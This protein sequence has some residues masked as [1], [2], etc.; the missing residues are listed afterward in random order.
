MT[1]DDLKRMMSLVDEKYIDEITQAA[2]QFA[3]DPEAAEVE[4]ITVQEAPRRQSWRIW[5]ALAAAVILCVPV[6]IGMTGG[7]RMLPEELNVGT[8]TGTDWAA[9]V[10]SMSDEEIAGY[11]ICDPEA[12]PT[13]E[14]GELTASIVTDSVPFA[15]EY[16]GKSLKLFRDDAGTVN[17]ASVTLNISCSLIM[18]VMLQ[19][20]ET[21]VEIVAEPVFLP[22]FEDVAF[23]GAYVPPTCGNTTEEELLSERYY[24]CYFR[25]GTTDYSMTSISMSQREL[26]THIYEVM[27]SAATPDSLYQAEL[28]AD[29]EQMQRAE[30][31]EKRR[32]EA[33]R[34][35]RLQKLAQIEQTLAKVNAMDFCKGWVPQSA[36]IGSLTCAK[37]YGS[38]GVPAES[39]KLSYA[40]ST[41]HLY[42]SFHSQSHGEEYLAFPG[43]AEMPVMTWEEWSSETVA[44][45]LHDWKEWEQRQSRY[46]TDAG[47]WFMVNL[48][49]CWMEVDAECDPADMDALVQAMSDIIDVKYGTVNKSDP[50][51]TAAESQ[52]AKLN[53]TGFCTGWVPQLA[54]IGEMRVITT[55]LPDEKEGYGSV[56]Y[57]KENT[58]TGDH[59]LYIRYYP[60]GTKPEDIAGP[61]PPVMNADQWS[62]ET[63]SSQPY[64]QYP[65]NAVTQ[66]QFVVDFDTFVLY[67][68]GDCSR[69]E[70]E[71]YVDAMSGLMTQNYGTKESSGIGSTDETLIWNDLPDYC[72]DWIPQITEIGTMAFSGGS[73]TSSEIK[74]VL[75]LNYQDDQT[76]HYLKTA[77]YPEA[78]VDTGSLGAEPVYPD[79][80]IKNLSTPK[81]CTV[82]DNGKNLYKFY[83]E[84]D[85]CILSVI[86]ECTTEEMAIFVD[87]ISERI[88][89]KVFVEPGEERVSLG[90]FYHKEMEE[91]KQIPFCKGMLPEL[92]R[93]GNMPFHNTG[94]S[95]MKG[96]YDS[97]Y[98]D[99]AAF[100]SSVAYKLEANWYS[101][102]SYTRQELG[103]AVITPDN[104][105]METLNT[106]KYR[107]DEGTILHLEKVGNVHV[108][109]Y[110]FMIDWGNCLMTVTAA[111]APEDMEI[112]VNEMS[113]LYANQQ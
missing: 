10:D 42:L 17:Q 45:M 63:I 76:G 105:S 106:E 81:Y 73:G 8:N 6:G 56:W 104:W 55:T 21:P 39:V 36:E 38:T 107:T 25:I 11:F 99:W 18:N 53:Q 80:T 29:R 65:E 41:S 64:C 51:T 86:A 111:C 32:A 5:A 40:N 94:H 48:G 74:N 112:F 7:F 103:Y 92:T 1:K 77:W 69:E 109:N 59:D 50:D 110:A 24:K 87:A 102:A 20:S 89:Q 47:Y 96:K 15:T 16:T 34:A 28:A 79:W 46:R 4:H 2:P 13:F 12:I 57:I 30:E 22:K 14:T 54:Y 88:E 37:G 66:Y 100:S 60:K 101:K 83:A 27:D 85:D 33:E 19:D 58:D 113:A 62:M 49:D 75:K 91:L 31:E 72:K 84:L 26:L 61:T 90:W 3:D 44:S 82:L 97:V 68:S 9:F 23:Y 70:M 108:Y 98:I 71:T 93:I 52:L 78:S 35:E 95:M 67:V 43:H